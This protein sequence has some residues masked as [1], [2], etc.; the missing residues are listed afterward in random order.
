M[1]C[2]RIFL[3]KREI[4]SVYVR[5]SLCGDGWSEWRAWRPS[6]GSLPWVW[7]GWQLFRLAGAQRAK[8]K[9]LGGI[10]VSGWSQKLLAVYRLELWTSPVPATPRSGPQKP[11]TETAS[12]PRPY[13]KMFL[14]VLP[15]MMDSTSF[16]EMSTMF[17]TAMFV[18]NEMC[19]VITT[20]GIACSCLISG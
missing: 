20:F 18:K 12:P 10:R 19:G 14:G 4:S 13:P 2:L 9:K 17:C 16:S 7:A 5:L 6:G 3:H 8:A 11:A 15:A 1:S